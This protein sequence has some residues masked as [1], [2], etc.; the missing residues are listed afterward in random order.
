MRYCGAIEKRSSTGSPLQVALRCKPNRSTYIYIRLV[1]RFLCALHLSIFEQPQKQGDFQ[2][3]Y[4]RRLSTLILIILIVTGCGRTLSRISPPSIEPL[5]LLR[6][7]DI[8]FADDLDIDSLN[9]ALERSIKYYEGRGRDNIYHIAER[10]ISARQMI[11][12]LLA[13][14]QIIGE[15]NNVA[16][17][18]KQIREKFDV[19][20]A[21]GADDN[22]SVLYTG[23][24]EPLLEGSLTRTEK[25]KYPLYKPPPD[26]IARKVSKNETKIFRMNNGEQVPYYSQRN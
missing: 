1:I 14:R 9:L 16:D 17:W 15:S 11:E 10:Q 21:Q 23:Y 2:Q 13:F 12:S 5:S 26:L 22:G 3:S 4:C 25:Y 6:A 20:K 19:Y 7:E 8:E 24:Y 18:Q